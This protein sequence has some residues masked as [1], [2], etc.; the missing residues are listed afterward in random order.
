[1]CKYPKSVGDTLSN[2]VNLPRNNS[3]LQGNYGRY[4]M[5]FVQNWDRGN[6]GGCDSHGAISSNTT[7]RR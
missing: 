4:N 3:G 5:A 2:A 1:M 6:H 7:M